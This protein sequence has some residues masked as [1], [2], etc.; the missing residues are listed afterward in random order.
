M[1]QEKFEKIVNKTCRHAADGMAY[2]VA[3]DWQGYGNGSIEL[4]WDCSNDVWTKLDFIP[5][6]PNLKSIE[7]WFPSADGLSIYW[8]GQDEADVYHE[9]FELIC[10]AYAKYQALLFSTS[11]LG[12]IKQNVLIEKQNPNDLFQ[13][14][15]GDCCYASPWFLLVNPRK[16]VVEWALKTFDFKSQLKVQNGLG[17]VEDR[18]A[19]PELKELI[20][21]TLK[22]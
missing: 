17:L 3:D 18:Q 20:L 1:T 19:I 15:I 10:E 6:D 11:N 9:F 13:Q 14:D 7:K 21:K 16:D 8:Y 5:S 22:T 4:I 12:T 2:M